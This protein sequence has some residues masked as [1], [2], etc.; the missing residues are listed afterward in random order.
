FLARF[1]RLMECL[2]RF[3]H[4]AMAAVGA[5]LTERNPEREDAMKLHPN[6]LEG[7]D[8]DTA[9]FYRHAIRCLKK[10]E[11]PFLVGGAYALAV[12][13]GIVRHTKDFDVFVRP[14]D[15]RRALDALAA[16]GYRTELTFSH[17]LGKAFHRDGFLDVLFSSG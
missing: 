2:A 8:P 1:L 5:A 15:C 7:L 4:K 9:L 6:T 12:Y 3:A 10:A 14:E 17:W 11:V 13:T 16:A